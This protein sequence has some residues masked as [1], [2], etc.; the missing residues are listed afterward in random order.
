MSSDADKTELDRERRELKHMRAELE[1]RAAELDRRQSKSA[2]DRRGSMNK[3]EGPNGGSPFRGERG[4][5]QQ[6]S[7]DLDK[8]LMQVTDVQG[9]CR[10]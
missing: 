3:T 9:H 8:S 5:S 2:T 1:R 7:S 6:S 4:I 10:I